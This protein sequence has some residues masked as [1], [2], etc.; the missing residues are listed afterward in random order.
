MTPAPPARPDRRVARTHRLLR[1]ALIALI[2]ERAWDEISVQDICDR[3]DIGRSTFYKHF[4]DKEALLTSGFED[5]HHELIAPQPVATKGERFPFLLPL[6]EHC[7]ENLGLWRALVGQRSGH[8]IQRRFRALLLDLVK[9]ELAREG[10][11]GPRALAT[12]HFVAGALY[13]TIAW[14]FD[15]T[16][17]VR[18][19]EVEALFRDLVGSGLG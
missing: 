10:R 18:P 3:A 1:E 4:G 16:P 2:A 5:L 9:G 11:T 15:T 14:W 13:E 6:L 17:L 7:R 19:Q 12:A 8:A